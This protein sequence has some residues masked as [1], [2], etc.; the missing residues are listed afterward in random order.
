LND[1]GGTLDATD[2]PEE[3]VCRGVRKYNYSAFNC[4]W[5]LLHTIQSLTDSEKSVM[6]E[7][8]E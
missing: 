8:V 1:L 6:G 4:I 2:T 5:N 3:Y 7:I